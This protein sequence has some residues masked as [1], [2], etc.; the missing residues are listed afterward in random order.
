MRPDN[1][2]GDRKNVFKY[3]SLAVRTLIDF[4]FFFAVLILNY[5]DRKGC[6]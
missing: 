2:Q 3:V 6:V 5:Q 4:F 1:W